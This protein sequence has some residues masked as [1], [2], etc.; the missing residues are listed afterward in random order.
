MLQAKKIQSGYGDIQV[1]WDVS[2][3]VDMGE[4]VVILGANG[5]GKTTIL[6][7]ISGIIPL[8]SGDIL[9]EGKSIA[10]LSP[11]MRVELGIIQVPEGRKLFPDMTVEE[12]LIV[13]SLSTHAKPKRKQNLEW[14]Y[15]LFPRLKERR[16]QMAGTLSGGEQQMCAI[17][18]GLMANPKIL[19]LDEPSLGLAP[20]IVHNL[21]GIIK[22]INEEGVT[23]L[24]VEQ[25]VKQ[26][27][28]ISHKAYI[29]ENG[30]IVKYGISAHLKED[31]AIKEAYLGI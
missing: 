1:L 21:F 28:D 12:N 25:N 26:S 7:T 17:A 13:G 22:K 6:R 5:S 31:P 19:M 24:L 2:F 8:W 11:A 16:K 20:I 4:I 23:I 10:K 27:L 14:C 18:R 29:I 9:Y 15:E 30:K 3:S